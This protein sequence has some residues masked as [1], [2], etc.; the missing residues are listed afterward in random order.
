MFS[1]VCVKNSVHGG[2]GCGVQAQARGGL[3][4]GMSRPR[5]RG[6]V[7]AKAWGVSRPGCVQ[8]QAKGVSRPRPGPRGVCIPACTEADT[9]NPADGYSCGWYASYW[10]AFL[11]VLLN[12]ALH[13]QR[14]AAVQFRFIVKDT[15]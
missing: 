1:Q 10:N 8:A 11:Y 2:G 13:T 4:R 5:S 3:P 9:P 6:G 7:Q 12:K 15:M 14:K